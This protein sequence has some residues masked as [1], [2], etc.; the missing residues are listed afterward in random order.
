MRTSHGDSRLYAGGRALASAGLV[1]LLVLRGAS[2]WVTFV[3]GFVLVLGLWVIG[4]GAGRLHLGRGCLQDVRVDPD[5][6]AESR[7]AE[8]RDALERERVEEWLARVGP[9]RRP[10]ERTNAAVPGG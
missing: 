3:A 4:R 7:L 5:L 8:L 9:Q 6:L 1:G 10:A 2:W